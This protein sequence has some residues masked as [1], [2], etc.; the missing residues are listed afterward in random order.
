[1]CVYEP[2]DRIGLAFLTG[3]VL[4]RGTASRPAGVIAEQLD[5]R[6]VSLR[7]STARHTMTVSCTCLAEDFDDV[8]AI[9]LDVVRSPVFPEPELAKRRAE[10][11]NALRQ[12]LD[13]PA[14]RAVESLFELLYGRHPYGRPAK[15]T[16]PVIESLSRDEIAAYHRSRFVPD[17]L[18]LAIV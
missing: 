1:G 16:I 2:A 10:T 14:V 18:S 7:V 8:L 4:D 15:G 9:V 5:D 17:Q 11:L 13:N 12:D 3:R 6:G